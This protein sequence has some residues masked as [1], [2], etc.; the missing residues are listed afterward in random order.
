VA[1]IYVRSTDGLDADNGSTWALAKATIT[2]ALNIA[3]PG[4]TI[5]VS[6]AHAYSTA[7]AITYP[8]KGNAALPITVMCVNDGAAPPTTLAATA[9]ETCTGTSVDVD[10]GSGSFIYWYGIT[11]KAARNLIF[12]PTGVQHFNNCNLQLTAAAAGQ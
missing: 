11:F 8:A 12:R 6:Q 1:Y 3:S 2:G 5:F 9:S 7:S 10:F 4:D